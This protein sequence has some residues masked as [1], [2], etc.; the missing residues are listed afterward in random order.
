MDAIL[1]FSSSQASFSP[2]LNLFTQDT[3]LQ[4][5]TIT[6]LDPP[7]FAVTQADPL[8]HGNTSLIHGRSASVKEHFATQN[9]VAC[10]TG[11]AQAGE[12][13]ETR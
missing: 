13:E 8:A 1:N 12:V 3:P 5:T 11:T 2:F 4:S 9:H 10:Q 7:P 6:L